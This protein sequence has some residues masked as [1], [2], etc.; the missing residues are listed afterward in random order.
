MTRRRLRP[1]A[2]LFSFAY[3][4][5]LGIVVGVALAAVVV[6]ASP[7]CSPVPPGVERGASLSTRW[8]SGEFHT[9]PVPS[10]P[11]QPTPS[12]QSRPE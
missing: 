8:G 2:P 10:E 5:T 12:A 4:I 11:V 1:A 3:P 9:R 6:A 7:A